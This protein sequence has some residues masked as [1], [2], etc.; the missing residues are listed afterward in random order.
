MIR[1]I[2]HKMHVWLVLL[3]K[4]TSKKNFIFLLAVSLGLCAGFAAVILKT[5]VHFI[6]TLATENKYTD[7][8]Y[9]LL[10]LPMLGIFL[11]YFIIKRILGGKLSKGLSPIHFS[12]AQK[13][14]DI[15]PE[16]TYA[17]LITSPVTVGLGGSAGLEAPIVITGAALGS[18]LAKYF[19][20]NYAERTLLLACGVA[21]GIGAAFNAPIAGVLFTI[22]VLMLDISTAGFIPLLIASASGALISKIILDE[23][24]LL[25]F[26]QQQPFDYS[27]VPYY[28]ILGGLAG[29]MS[30]YHAKLFVKVEKH[31]SELKIHPY[32][33]MIYAGLAL[34]LIIWL[35]P[36]LFGE[37]YSS[38]KSLASIHP[39]DVLK[40]SLLQNEITNEWLLLFF[41]LIVMGV[42]AI[43]TGITL[44]GGGNGGNFA[45]S[46]F[47][48]SYLGFIYAKF[49]NLTHIGKIP[50]SNFTLVGMAG[51]L[52]GL[53]HAPLTA[54]F[55]I[56]EIT[57]G[58]SLM[59]PLMIVTSISYFVSK[60]I[61]R[62][63]MDTKE[64]IA[65][66]KIHSGNKDENILVTMKMDK[67]IETNFVILKS[68]DN[69]STLIQAI[70]A[71][72]RNIFP[73]TDQNKKLLGIVLL[74]DVKNIIFEQEKYVDLQIKDI[75][76][77]F[78]DIIHLTDDMISV[79]EKFELTHAWNLPVVDKEVYIGFI[80]KSKLFSS[81]RGE[82]ISRTLG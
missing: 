7:S 81:Y 19:R 71:S 11:T 27:N 30:I 23:G 55:L 76:K 79:V 16:Q 64:L 5:A 72:E 18:N 52:S 60:S 68:T 58:Y 9:I 36:T 34:A 63:S 28:I 35:F 6:F 80:S 65:S 46:L 51:V 77:P 74:N 13:S 26:Q 69:I 48:G 3:Q 39:E 15:P 42:K 43:A 45:P 56:A 40:N 24:T 17:Q 78:P 25:S 54:I 14:S 10:L 62:Y 38:I 53:Y 20:L 8:K 61:E 59:I 1:H 21:A 57:G 82:L 2:L 49:I 67:L 44:G 33:R 29:L 70:V 31:F 37:G 12:I 4:K 73:V 50:E 22:E 32:L 47:V 66:R 75:M 41:I